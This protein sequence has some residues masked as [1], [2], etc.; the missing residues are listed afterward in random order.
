MK[1]QFKKAVEAKLK[2][3][4]DT[5]VKQLQSKMKNTVKNYIQRQFERNRPEFSFKQSINHLIK[6]LYQNLDYQIQ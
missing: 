5:K 4:V 3:K 6:L 2:S 1:D